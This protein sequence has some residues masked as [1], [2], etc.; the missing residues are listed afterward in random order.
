[1]KLWQK[2]LKNGDEHADGIPISRH[3]YLHLSIFGIVM[4]LGIVLALTVTSNIVPNMRSAEAVM[5]RERNK[6]REDIRE[7]F[8]GA[9][10]ETVTLSKMLSADIESIL[11]G[12]AEW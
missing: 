2:T 10:A 9:A 6:A 1:M 12:A 4:F 7:H 8:G 3:I 5:L 11:N